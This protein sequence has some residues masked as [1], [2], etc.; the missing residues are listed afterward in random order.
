MSEDRLKSAYELAMERLRA[1]DDK[2]G[3]R[4]AKGLNAKQKKEIKR[5]REE[6]RAKLAELEILHKKDV[7]AAQ[8]DPEKLAEL[9]QHY[10][11]DRRRV[12][13]NLESAI[14]RIRRPK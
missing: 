14:E 7:A 4:P 12:E 3:V 2:K 11:I 9:E 8:G 5:L 13:S 6:A 10:Q 1:E